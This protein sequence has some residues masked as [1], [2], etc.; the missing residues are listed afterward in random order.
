V[1]N[2]IEQL[3]RA[4]VR[5]LRVKYLELF[6]QP[7]RSNHKQFLFRRVAWRLQALAYGELSAQARQRAL[8]LAHDADLRIKAPS[9]LV[10]ATPQFVAADTPKPEQAG[11]GSADSGIG[12]RAAAEVQRADGG[13]SGISGRLSIPGRFYRSLSA[14]ARQVTGTQWNG[15]AFFD[16]E[17][18]GGGASDALRARGRSDGCSGMA[19]S[20]H[21]FS[22]EARA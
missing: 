20:R 18:N 16:L 11:P 19:I 7:S 12:Q 15:Y 6:G 21:N 4:T 3:R 22:S 10:G 13:R 1:W 8:A 5:E 2:E 14:I 9:H 17:A